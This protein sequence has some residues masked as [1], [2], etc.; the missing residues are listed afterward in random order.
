[1]K[2]YIYYPVGNCITVDNVTGTR[3]RIKFILYCV[4]S[5]VSYYIECTING[6][7]LLYRYYM[8]IILHIIII[9]YC[10]ISMDFRTAVL[11]VLWPVYW[12]RF[13]ISTFRLR[14]IWW[15]VTFDTSS[16]LETCTCETPFQILYYIIWALNPLSRYS[17]RAYTCNAVSLWTFQQKCGRKVYG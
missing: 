12:L 1:M 5:F 2:Y 15:K 8:Y 4:T 16:I 13:K 10:Q 14:S 17:P 3:D 11:N 7:L 6:T 9:Y